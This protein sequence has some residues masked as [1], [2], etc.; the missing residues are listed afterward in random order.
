[1]KYNTLTDKYGMALLWYKSK[2]KPLLINAAF[3]FSSSFW[4]G[5]HYSRTVNY[6]LSRSLSI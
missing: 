5:T 2:E 6:G 3:E 1:M 4:L